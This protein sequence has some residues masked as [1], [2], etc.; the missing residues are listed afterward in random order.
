MK[1]VQTELLLS[2]G[3]PTVTAV[4]NT[5]T[6]WRRCAQAGEGQA[7]LEVPVV[8]LLGAG[9]GAEV[10]GHPAELPCHASLTQLVAVVA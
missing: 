6:G 3:E 7:D 1:V 4:P 10:P 8:E 5:D 2:T 9:L